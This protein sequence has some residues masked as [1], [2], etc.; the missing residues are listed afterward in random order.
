MSMDDFP[1]DFV[2]LMDAVE[3]I[4]LTPETIHHAAAGMAL[5][6]W[7]NTPTVETDAHSEGGWGDADMLRMNT[8]AT[9]VLRNALTELCA[10]HAAAEDSLLDAMRDLCDLLPDE[11]MKDDL[12][13][14]RTVEHPSGVQQSKL[15]GPGTCSRSSRWAR[16]EC[17]CRAI[18]TGGDIP[19]I[20][21]ASPG[22]PPS[23]RPTRRRSPCVH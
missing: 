14:T 22:W 15:S 12:W 20:R 18:G 6:L 16:P 2:D 19:T 17:L 8:R 4:E 5:L 7:R 9:Q 11:A 3:P 23:I 21:L 10:E 13:R 1:Q